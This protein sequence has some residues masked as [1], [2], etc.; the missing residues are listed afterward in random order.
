[1]HGN[2]VATVFE[3]ENKLTASR[4]AGRSLLKEMYLGWLMTQTSL[5]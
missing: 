5:P 4:D 3:M 1:M 2:A